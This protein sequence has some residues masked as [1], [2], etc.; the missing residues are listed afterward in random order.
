MT[1]STSVLLSGCMAACEVGPIIINCRVSVDSLDLK[2][3]NYYIM[4]SKWSLLPPISL[5]SFT[6][7]VIL[8]N[9]HA[10]ASLTS[11]QSLHVP[12]S[13]RVL[14]AVIA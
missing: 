1:S 14:G 8:S 3:N 6:L 11:I 7:I 2:Y 10:C 9:I 5:L 4:R 13:G 12:V